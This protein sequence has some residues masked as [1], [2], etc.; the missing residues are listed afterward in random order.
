MKSIMLS[1]VL[2]A[3]CVNATLETSAHD[4]QEF[5]LGTVPAVNVTVPVGFEAALSTKI[6][7]ALKKAEEPTNKLVDSVTL[8]GAV[9]TA[10]LSTDST[11][12]GVQGC[13]IALKAGADSVTI[14]DH[15]LSDRER[16][17]KSVALPLQNASLADVRPLLE[18][19][20][21]SLGLTLQVL[22]AQLTATKVMTDLT[23]DVSADIA[24]S[25]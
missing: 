13:Q 18:Q 23:L 5:N 8:D 3:G 11:L 24:A 21:P 15:Q 17:G 2:L 1:V 16:S 22:P 19:S 4:H 14:V 6:A 20:N 25:L 9:T 7:Q 10:I 12:A